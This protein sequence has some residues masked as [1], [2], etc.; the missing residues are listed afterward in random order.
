ME[1]IKNVL[2]VGVGG[3]G[4]ILASKILTIG[5]IEAGYDVKMAE[6]HGM[7]QRGGSVTTQVRYGRKVYSPI[8]G[9]GDG[10]VLVAFEKMEALRILEDLK[11]GGTVVVNDYVIAPTPVLTGECEYP[12]GIIE[13]LQA[14]ANTVAFNAAEVAADLGN[15]KCMNVV[16]LGALVKA[17]NLIEIDWVDIVKRTIKPAFVDINIAALKA[18]MS[19]Q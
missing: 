9:H 17:L 13:E 6:V 11:P 18:G 10:D 16:L 3:Q 5:L 7:S 2:L 19:I 15:L 1:N 8:I 12:D 14:K 4:T